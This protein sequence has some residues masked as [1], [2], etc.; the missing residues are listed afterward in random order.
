MFKRKHII[1]S[2]VVIVSILL[3]SLFYYN[4]VRAQS[5]GE[6]DPWLDVNDDGIIDVSDIYLVAL[7]FGAMGT[8]LTKAAMEY[9]SGWV[10]IS[11]KKG[12]YFDV[13][14][15]LHL[16]GN[17]IPRVWGKTTLQAERHQ[18]CFDG[19]GSPSGWSKTYGGTSYDD[20]N[21]VVE[22][23]DGG[24]AVAG[25]TWSYGAGGSDFYLVKT[26][27]AGNMEW[28][29]TYGTVSDEKPNSLIVTSDGGYAIAGST[30]SLG[31]S[32]FWLVKTDSAGNYE[33]SWT[34]LGTGDNVAYSVIETSDGGYAIA[35]WVDPAGPD[36]KDFRLIKTTSTGHKS[37]DITYGGSS[38]DV[39]RSVVETS[40]GGYALA[41]Y[42]WSYGA[43][44]SDYYLV[45]TDADGVMQWN[46]TY[47][48]GGW[49]EAWP[50]I[51]TGDGGYALAG[52]TGSYGAGGTDFWLVKTNSSGHMQWSK[53][54]GGADYEETRSLVETIDGGYAIA[55]FTE[56]YGAGSK[57]FYLVKTDVAGN[58]LW[59]KTYGGSN[60]EFATSLVE[61]IDGGYALAGFTYSYGAGLNDFYL[62]KT[63][64]FGLVDY[65]EVGLAL[66]AYTADTLTFYRGK[67]DPYWNY[68]RV[69]IF[70]MR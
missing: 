37:W 39:A 30:L 54:Y 25:N 21:A 2:S 60:P 28:N 16:T 13:V 47:G 26:D 48:G 3:G 43:G 4:M 44:Y 33:W 64:P 55:G 65:P 27:S 35:G 34:Y 59:S 70:V 6:Y 42:T 9:D 61:T 50:L 45:K 20:A 36:E 41:G 69:Y 7:R 51:E 15:N 19:T 38:W 24:Y 10:D 1:L 56:S 14:H 12:Q 53:T 23:G 5:A 29:T 67:I 46:K 18:R 58:M 11:D 17:F 66:T 22:T 52:Y 63:D 32:N 57:D 31:G 40:G 8:S 49:D 62:V 68:I